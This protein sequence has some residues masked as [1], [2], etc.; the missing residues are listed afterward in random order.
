M[1]LLFASSPRVVN[2]TSKSGSLHRS[3]GGGG[4][5]KSTATN[6]S[7]SSST[8]SITTTDITMTVR[9]GTAEG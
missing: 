2:S 9:C 7:S 8:P 6:C 5:E 3:A 1:R 4:G